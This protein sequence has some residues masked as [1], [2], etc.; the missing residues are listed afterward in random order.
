MFE[1]KLLEE[2]ASLLGY[3]IAAVAICSSI[4]FLA[5]TILIRCASAIG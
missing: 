2:F 3:L 5:L 4:L 1:K